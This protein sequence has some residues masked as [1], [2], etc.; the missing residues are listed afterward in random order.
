MQKL[1]GAAIPLLAALVA[2]AF[3]AI[4]LLAIGA[5][6]IEGFTALV[7]GA[8]GTGPRLVATLIKATPLLLVGAGITI[9]FRANVINIGGEGQIVA[10]ALLSSVMAIQ[11]PDLPSILL[12]P[13]VLL[14]GIVGGGIWGAIPGVLKAYAS[15]NEILSTIMLNLVAIQLMNFLLRGW[16]IDP[17]EVERGTRIPQ[18]AR[19]SENAELPSLIPGSRLHLGVLVGVLAAV[20]AY[21]LLWRTPLGFRLRA[22]GHSPEAARAAGI[23][24]KRSIVAALA[25]SGALS[26]L[27]GTILVFGSEAVRMGTDGSSVGF[28]GSAGFNGI[29]AALFG[30]LHPLWTIPSSFLF[31]G[32]LTGATNLQLKLQVPAALAVAL[33]GIVVV[34]VVSSSHVRARLERL[35]KSRSELREVLR[36]A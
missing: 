26:G 10:G 20:A 24:V 2:F 4:M 18:T 35:A 11:L 22:V 17:L 21:I 14:A 19:L 16:M 34:F 30:G 13:L 6:P 15:V 9:A 12:I 3:G 31:G 8:V 36:D 7:D 5:N 27:A 33:N 25:L 23:P 28:T 1:L 32:L 29:V